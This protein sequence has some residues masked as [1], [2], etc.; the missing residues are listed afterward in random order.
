MAS[1]SFDS[2]T[3]LSEEMLSSSLLS[4]RDSS[5]TLESALLI[6]PPALKAFELGLK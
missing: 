4:K 5:I 2:T 6:A 3:S 1:S